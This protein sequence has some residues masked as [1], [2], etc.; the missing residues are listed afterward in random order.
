MHNFSPHTFH[1]PV[2]GIGY[3]IDSPLK[4][5]HLG[6][7]SVVSLVDDMLMEKM[8]EFH[9]KSMN[10]PFQGISSKVADFRAR[11]I[12]AFLDLMDGMVKEKIAGMKNSFS[13]KSEEVDKYFEMLPASSKAR[14]TYFYLKQNANFNDLKEWVWENLQPG[15]IDVNIMTKLDKPNFA[16]GEQ[17]PVEFNDAHA[18]LR[19]FAQSNLSSSLVLSAG[20]NPRLFSYMEKWD[21][22]YPDQEGLIKKKVTIKVS[23]FRSA[24]VQGKMLAK[25]G[26]W[27]SEFR[28]ESGLNCG[29]HAFASQGNLMGPVL[30]EF[31]QKRNELIN[32]QFATFCAGLAAKGMRCPEQAPALRFSAQGGVGTAAEHQFLLQHYHLDSVGW[33]T[34]FLMVPEAVSID[35]DTINKLGRA[36]EKDLYLSD[37]SPLGVPFNNLRG[38]T[39]DLEKESNIEANRPGS[40][41]T[42]QYC[43]LNS[44]FSGR[45]V[46][47]ASRQYQRKKILLAEAELSSQA[48]INQEIKKITEKS[49]ICV[50]LG[51]SALIANGISHLSEG[52]GVSVCP[53]P[54]MAYFDKE[55]SLKEMA[56]HIYGRENI[57]SRSDRPHIFL[58]ELELYV[59]Y[60]FEKLKPQEESDVRKK[61]ANEKFLQA[62][63][64]SIEYYRAMYI[65]QSAQLGVVMADVLGRLRF[66]E[67]QVSGFSVA[68]K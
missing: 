34:P 18:A 48:A 7:T 52:A 9:S 5:A 31:K 47:T 16:G 53:G 35:A 19:G 40:N 26:I 4:L 17:L 11:R 49:C 12:T 20:M 61:A 13:R 46:C 66:F 6:I 51:T 43:S 62:I 21:D 57:M 45:P 67:K 36:K 3:T 60:F 68:Q 39:K 54:N 58:K 64:E 37:I 55:A 23:D 1:V 59:N 27:V 29:G 42:K 2:M 33:G 50:G 25:K 14:Q 63:S 30:E 38:N 32:D 56:D 41:C 44:E 8:R 22:F 15:E 24:V 28:I 65:R 10:S